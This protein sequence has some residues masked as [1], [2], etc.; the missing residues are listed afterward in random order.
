MDSKLAQAVREARLELALELALR[1][2]RKVEAE[3]AQALV[4]QAKARL[5]QAV[6][7]AEARAEVVEMEAAA[8]AE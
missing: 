8:S 1:E 3:Q 7:E 5:A 4:E 2:M 6:R